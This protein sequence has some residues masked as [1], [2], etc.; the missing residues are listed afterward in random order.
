MENPRALA[1]AGLEAEYDHCVAGIGDTIME[2]ARQRATTTWTRFISFAA[3]CGIGSLSD[4]TPSVATAF[5]HSRTSTGS[6]PSRQSMHNRRTCLRQLFR[7]ARKVGLATA[8]PTI[9]LVLPT[10]SSRLFR[11]LSNSEINLCRDAASLWTSSQRFSAVWALA[12]ASARGAELGAV[13]TTDL[14]LAAGRVWLSGSL[15]VEP[16]WGVLTKWGATVLAQ[17]LAETSNDAFVAFQG[18]TAGSASRVSAAS[19]VTAVLKRAGLG[20]YTDVRPMSV[21]AW[22]G[23]TAFDR[24]GDIAATAHLLGLRSLDATARMIGWDWAT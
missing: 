17:R 11:P 8:D 10:R 16:R 9:D 19:A 2:G 23:R 5:I 24:D 6:K 13:R 7:V 18:S 1:R 14:D 21:A 4:V 15:R 20:D 12:E 22:A 3:A